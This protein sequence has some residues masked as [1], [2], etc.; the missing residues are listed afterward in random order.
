MWEGE[1][2]EEG[3]EER[4]DESY[5]G[6]RVRGGGRGKE[7]CEGRNHFLGPEMYYSNSGIFVSDQRD[8]L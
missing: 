3:V 4:Q 8:L 5:E 2:E 1:G 7:R 6:G